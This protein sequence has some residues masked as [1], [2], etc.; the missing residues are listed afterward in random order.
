MVFDGVLGVLVAFR[1]VWLVVP[2]VAG[3]SVTGTA[4]ATR[5]LGVRGA[6]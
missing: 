4:K 5:R 2:G 1:A 3:V 6:G